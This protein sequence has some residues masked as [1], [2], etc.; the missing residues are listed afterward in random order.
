MQISSQAQQ[1]SYLLDGSRLSDAGNRQESSAVEGFTGDLSLFQ[2]AKKKNRLGIFAKILEGLSVKLHKGASGDDEAG[3]TTLG[4]KG[5]NALKS[6]AGKSRQSPNELALF[7]GEIPEEGFLTLSRQDETAALKQST[8]N[9]LHVFKKDGELALARQNSN[10]EIMPD[11]VYPDQLTWEKEGQAP[12]LSILGNGETEK[13]AERQGSRGLSGDR[14]KSQRNATYFSASF[15][16]METEFLQSRSLQTKAGQEA[17][18]VPHGAE[19]ENARL[20]RGKRGKER[21]SGE[22]RDTRAWE[23]QSGKTQSSEFAGVSKEAA[24][25]NNRSSAN[26]EIEIQMDLNLNEGKPKAAGDAANPSNQARAFEDALAAELRG[27]LSTDIVQNAAIIVRGGGEG[28]IRLS[29]H[30]ASLGDVKI[31][32]EMTENKITGHI[33]LQSDEALRAFEKELPVLE[34]AFRDSGFSETNLEMFLTSENSA[35]DGNFGGQGYQDRDFLNQVLA[36]SRYDAESERS[37]LDR[38]EAPLEPSMGFGRGGFSVF[39]RRPVNLL[40]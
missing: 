17:G 39:G 23:V 7:D 12:D 30:P 21:S 2:G 22:I 36:A 33:I 1:T 31:R 10:L 18:L 6:G 13:E 24:G 14:A 38:L 19:K 11:E 32:L 29:L 34:K 15:R 28:T 5:K 27:N 25:L 20:E 9:D 8:F 40:V 4:L 35:D 26:P 37:G 3:G 16:E